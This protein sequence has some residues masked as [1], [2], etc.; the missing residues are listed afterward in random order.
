MTEINETRLLAIIAAH[1]AATGHWPAE[2]RDAALALLETSTAARRALNEAA[3]LDALLA[4]DRAPPVSLTLRNRIAAIPE[5][6]P[7][8]AL[9]IAR[10]FWPFGAMWRPASGLAA[11]A[12]I[13]LVVGIGTPRDDVAFAATETEAYSAVI[14]AAGGEIEEI[15]Q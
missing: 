4:E 5:Q 3:R 9:E 1:G 8:G 6:R 13:G 10:L 2:E 14:A 11:A 15:P 7:L 12:I